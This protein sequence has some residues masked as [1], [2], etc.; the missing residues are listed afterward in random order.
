MIYHVPGSSKKESQLIEINFYK[1]SK[2]GKSSFSVSSVDR[3]APRIFAL[4]KQTTIMDV[5]RL[6]LEKMRGIFDTVPEG[7]EALN[8]LI[9]VH[10]RENCPMVKKGMYTRTRANC[11]FCGDKHSTSEEYCDLKLDGQEVNETVESSTAVT[12]GDLIAK[13]EHERPL[14]LAIVLKSSENLV[15]FNELRASYRRHDG[16]EVEEGEKALTLKSCFVGFSG[17]ETLGGDDQWYCNICKEHRD[18]TKK[19]ELYSVP[20]IFI[21]Q[22]KRFQ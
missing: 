4:T 5:K 16:E 21:I 17:E 7:D 19:L 20:K 12:L 6:I 13:M 22:L 9:E 8:D 14:I 10:V 15:N 11:E 2:R 1:M 3:S 18:I